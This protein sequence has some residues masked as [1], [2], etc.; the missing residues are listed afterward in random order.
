MDDWKKL[1]PIPQ[2]L[3]EAWVAHRK[4]PWHPI[5]KDGP[6]IGGLQKLTPQP[7]PAGVADAEASMTEV[8]LRERPDQ[9]RRA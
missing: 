9:I 4:Y 5:F 8:P 7:Q 6:D 1:K 3:I 2:S